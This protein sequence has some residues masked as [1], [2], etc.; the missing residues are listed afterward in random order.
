MNTKLILLYRSEHLLEEQSKMA[1]CEADANALVG[2]VPESIPRDCPFQTDDE[3]ED[4]HV[5]VGSEVESR[6]SS[7]EV[8]ETSG[9]VD[10]SGDLGTA[11]LED[12]TV[13]GEVTTTSVIVVDQ[14]RPLDPE[15]AQDDTNFVSRRYIGVFLDVL[16]DIG[17]PG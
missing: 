1:T 14:A 10:A 11:P 2:S 6:S 16:A 13:G 12:G 8:I 15:V 17:S 3:I 7:I 9:Q 4:P 5:K